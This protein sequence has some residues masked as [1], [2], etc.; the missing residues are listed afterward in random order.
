MFVP[1]K[2]LALHPL[3][4]DTLSPG[5]KF[6]INSGMGGSFT[7]VFVGFRPDEGMADFTIVGSEPPPNGWHGEPRSFRI[8]ELH[9]HLHSLPPE[10]PFLDEGKQ[11]LIQLGYLGY[12]KDSPEFVSLLQRFPRTR[13]KLETLDHYFELHAQLTQTTRRERHRAA[14]LGNPGR[15][16][17]KQAPLVA[18]MD[19]IEAGFKSRFQDYFPVYHKVWLAVRQPEGWK[20]SSLAAA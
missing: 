7:V 8:N 15:Y 1:A 3:R 4:K 13:E 19:A 14:H 10:C 2:C 20:P 11:E 17:R 6:H 12:P 18:E 9:L 5:E 16:T